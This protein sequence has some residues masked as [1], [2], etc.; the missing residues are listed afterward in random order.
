MNFL[1]WLNRRRLLFLQ[2]RLALSLVHEET[3]REPLIEAVSPQTDEQVLV[4]GPNSTSMTIS[5][6]A[7]FRGTH[8][9]AT[10]CKPDAVEKGRSRS[11]TLGVTLQLVALD[12]QLPFAAGTFDKVILALAIHELP[13]QEKL[14]LI[15]EARRTLRQSGV[16]Y[17][18]DYDKP[19]LPREVAVFTL[20]S[21]VGNGSAAAPHMDGSWIKLFAR[22]GLRNVTYLSSHSVRFGRVALVRARKL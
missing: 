18:A 4:L 11:I 1:S 3:W 16:L 6:A 5:L 15:K 17:A 13:L 19:T 9:T 8:F 12:Q 10:D 7:R 21:D 2:R 22:A 14:T 20:M